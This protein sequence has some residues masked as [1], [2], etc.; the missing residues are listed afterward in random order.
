[1]EQPLHDFRPFQT[2]NATPRRFVGVAFVIALHLVVIWALATGL[3]ANLI[4]KIPKDIVAAVIPPKAEVKPPPPPPPELQKPPPPFVPPPEINIQSEAP[5]TNTI[6]VQSKVSA[7]APVAVAPPPAPPKPAGITSPVL[8]SGHLDCA[9]RYYPAIATRLN[10]QGTTLITIHVAAEGRVSGVDI[11]GSS[12][13]DSLDQA[14][15]R[16]SSTWHFKPALQDG[17]PVASTKQMR[18]TW[19]LQ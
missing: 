4:A 16:C 15:I 19:K 17:Q 7:P 1:M 14:S 6:T 3:A 8:S 13:Y 18:V 5:A 9:D 2:A 10:Q 11:T 12:G